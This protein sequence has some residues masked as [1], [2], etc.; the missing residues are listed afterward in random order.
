VIERETFIRHNWYHANMARKSSFLMLLP[1]LLVII[2]FMAGCVSNPPSGGGSSVPG[3]SG[4]P[5]EVSQYAGDWPLPN[6]D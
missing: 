3:T 4:I 6:K 1:I 2:I 5:P